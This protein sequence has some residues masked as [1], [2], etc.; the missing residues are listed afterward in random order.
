MKSNICM[1]HTFPKVLTSRSHRSATWVVLAACGLALSACAGTFGA[2]G[3]SSWAVK[4]LDGQDYAGEIITL[5]DL[6][7]AAA[8]RISAFEQSR[9]FSRQLGETE[10]K[11]PVIGP[12]DLLDVALWEAP[13]ATL[14]GQASFIPGLD[15]GAQGRPIL[16]QVVDSQGAITIPFAGRIEV[17]G[18]T[19][20]AVEREIVR[21]LKGR[22]NDPQAVVKLA[23]ND[24]RNVTV[25]GEVAASRRVPIGPRGERLLDILAIAGGARAPVA[26]T[27]VQVNRGALSAAMPLEAVINDPAQN[28][29]LQPDDVVT[30]LHQPYSFVALGAFN[31]S[32]EIPFEGRGISLAEA[33]ARAG[34]L[35]DNRANVGGVYVFRLEPAGALEPDQIAAAPRTQDGRVPVVYRLNLRDARGFFIAQD[36]KM[37]DKDVIYVSVAPGADIRDFL[38]T[39][40]SLAFSAIAIGNVLESSN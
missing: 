25:L 7:E 4:S 5:V 16:Q 3:P 34:G 6:S 40:T 2:P 8:S 26:Q 39:V 18:M 37:R 30:V 15:P 32:A 12:G 35:R 27:S 17:A 20:A 38:S 19:P 29:R 23:G 10:V 13:P 22:A 21:R 33:I 1:M 11:D 14:F 36:F 24:S 28:V 9:T 31:K